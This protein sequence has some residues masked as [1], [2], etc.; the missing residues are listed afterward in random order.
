MKRNYFI[1]V[2]A[3]P[4]YGRLRRVHIPHY[5]LHIVA[6][7]LVLAAIAGVGFVSSYTRMLGKVSEFNQLRTEKTALQKRYDELRDRVEESDADCGAPR[8]RLFDPGF[9]HDRV[10]VTAGGRGHI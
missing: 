7:L 3:H 6:A 10:G 2:L 9:L 5:A 8:V 4:I 1:V